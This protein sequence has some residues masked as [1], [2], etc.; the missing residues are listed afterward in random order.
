MQLPYPRLILYYREKELLQ[1]T[2][3]GQLKKIR[4]QLKKKIINIK[5]TETDNC[6]VTTE[7]NILFLGNKLLN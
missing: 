5:F 7:E 4:K 1:E 6:T 2:L 3:L